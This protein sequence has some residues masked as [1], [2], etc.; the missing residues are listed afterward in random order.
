[1]ALIVLA[2]ASLSLSAAHHEPRQPLPAKTAIADALRSPQVRQGLAGVRWS[3][4]QA[5]GVDGQD[6]RVSFYAGSRMVLDALVRADGTVP[7]VGTFTH[8]GVPYGD[9]IAYEPSVL[10]V[11]S[12]VFVLMVGVVP[13]RRL[14]NLDVLATL[15]LLP[16]VVA[17]QHRYIAFSAISAAPGVCY[18]IAR[19]A[20]RGLGGGGP[21]PS[22][23][24]LVD[25]LTRRWP[26]AQRVHVLRAAL[27]TLAL[28]Y[29][30]VGVSSPAPD[31]VAYAVME[32]ATKIVH[33]V[34]PYGHLPGDVFHGDTYPI[35]SY[36]LYAP[37]ARLAP[38]K[39]T[40]SSVDGELALTAL[41]ALLTAGLLA[42]STARR[43][44][45]TAAPGASAELPG[46]RAAIALLAFPP[47]LIT[48]SAGTTDVA[49]GAMLLL[50]VLL[51]RRP[52]ASAG[53]LAAAGWFK[54]APFALV[55]VWLAP[56]RG[57]RLLGAGAAVAAVSLACLGLVV[58]LGGVAGGRTMAHAIG[59]QFNRES[60]QSA[61]YALGITGMQP[62]GEAAVIALIAGAS[63]RLWRDRALAADRGRVAALTA[64]VLLGLQF[65]SSQWAFMYLAWVLPLV[66]LSLFA[67]EEPAS[68]AQLVMPAAARPALSINLGPVPADQ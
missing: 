34:L 29:L 68:D 20:W 11:L 65:S 64:A 44:R 63:V 10:V 16:T 38:V 60:P 24:P 2:G 51:W 43:A 58:A 23:V 47:L 25:Q 37:L 55:P 54:L 53:V 9:W 4:A 42:W 33:G 12:A 17:L 50:A 35:L 46:L 1:V 6:E 28:V 27:V 15:S 41:A 48:V 36:A 3:M 14:R 40:W 21:P 66:G 13:L 49:L 45:R 30:M 32:G 67:D 5:S 19:C 7:S 8:G 59:Y 62:V 22:S 18:L 61:W 57:R 56:L 52:A 39:A 26:S 31:D